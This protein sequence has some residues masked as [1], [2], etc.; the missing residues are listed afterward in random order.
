MLA[1]GYNL[2]SYVTEATPMPSM[3]TTAAP[4][5]GNGTNGSYISPSITTTAT[6]TGTKC[7]NGTMILAHGGA[8]SL[9]VEGLSVVLGG[10]S[11]VMGIMLVL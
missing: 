4:G 11:M 1:D 3:T 6:H 7:G 9:K 8:A 5:C 2:T 10:L